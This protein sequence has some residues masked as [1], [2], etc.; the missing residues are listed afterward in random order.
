MSNA[1]TT[2]NA[3][4]MAHS[5]N[6]RPNDA[7]YQTLYLVMATAVILVSAVLQIDASGRVVLP[8][9]QL[10]LPDTCW[11]HR[12]FGL[13][14]PG[15]GLTRCFI[16]IVHGRFAEAWHFNPAGFPFFLLVASQ[17]PYRAIQL[18]RIRTGVGLLAVSKTPL[19]LVFAT[20]V[21]LFAQWLLRVFA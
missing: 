5:R 4:P 20:M 18:W 13:G 21:L 8:V 7:F 15:C 14:C 19:I 1:T 9:L 11:F 17:I 3:Q 12:I 10:P 6:V 2:L 16:S